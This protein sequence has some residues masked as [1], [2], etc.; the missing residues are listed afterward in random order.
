[1]NSSQFSLIVV[2]VVKIVPKLVFLFITRNIRKLTNKR[3]YFQIT[4]RFPEDAPDNEVRQIIKVS[5]MQTL[6]DDITKSCNTG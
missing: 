4:G 5:G 2:F 3:N 6:W 1:M